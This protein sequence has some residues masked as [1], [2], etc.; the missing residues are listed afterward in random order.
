M[1][2]IV[3][4]YRKEDTKSVAGRLQ[5]FLSTRFGDKSVLLGVE[6]LIQPGDDFQIALVNGAKA[7]D[8]LIL[9]IGSQWAGSWQANAEDYD[10]IALSS[11]L[12]EGK[13]VIPVL[14]NG[15]NAPTSDQLPGGL[16]P[17]ARRTPMT[18]SEDTFRDDATKL[19]DSIAKAGGTANIAQ[20][21][22]QVSSGF[23]SSAA[24]GS[25]M[26][27]PSGKSPLAAALL[28]FFLFGGIGQIYL[29]QTT[30]GLAILG[31]Y[32]VS[33]CLLSFIGVGF[34]L[35]LLI[36]VV[37]AVDAYQIGMRLQN[38]ESVAAWKFF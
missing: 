15:A 34:I 25:T 26:V 38:G 37:G 29:G 21:S 22:G 23:S 3:I 32:F 9:L 27:S 28:S 4:S 31:A 17:L 30:K 8:T 33:A 2:R 11:A 35:A 18:L 20:P 1:P 24:G 7:A 12:A 16:A 36:A 19:A 10:M 13:R 6:G 14:V 5:D